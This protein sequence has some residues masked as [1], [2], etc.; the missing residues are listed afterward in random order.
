MRAVPNGRAVYLQ[1][2]IGRRYEQPPFVLLPRRAL[3]ANR[4]GVE[5]GVDTDVRVIR[6]AVGH[7]TVGVAEVDPLDGSVLSTD[8]YGVLL[9]GVCAREDIADV[10]KPVDLVEVRKSVGTP[11]RDKGIASA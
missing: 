5:K 10:I 8:I 2:L 9:G 6:V 7:A 3:P 11:N 4:L 1:G